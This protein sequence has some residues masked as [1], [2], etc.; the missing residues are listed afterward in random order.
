MNWGELW[1]SRR[2][3]AA[4]V[5][6]LAAVVVSVADIESPQEQLVEWILSLLGVGTAAWVASEKRER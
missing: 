6:L 2:F 1:T 3:I 4:L 5:A